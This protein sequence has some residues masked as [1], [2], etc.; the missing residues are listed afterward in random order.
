MLT[1]SEGVTGG[2][3]P[4]TPQVGVGRTA[5]VRTPATRERDNCRQHLE[6]S[7][8]HEELQDNDAAFANY[9]PPPSPTPQP[10]GPA[11]EFQ[12]AVGHQPVVPPL[13][14]RKRCSGCRRRLPITDFTLQTNQD[15]HGQELRTCYCCC[16]ANQ[17]QWQ[18][19]RQQALDAIAQ[20]QIQNTPQPTEQGG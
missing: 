2:V 10:L 18:N 5:A 9:N 11:M 6:Q 3:G 15:V 12:V 16:H 14:I 4:V 17:N 13:P 20:Q 7:G 19:N 8:D 1:S